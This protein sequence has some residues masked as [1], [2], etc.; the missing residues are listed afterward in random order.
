MHSSPVAVNIVKFILKILFSVFYRV[1]I[2]G[3][4]NIPE[5]GPVLLCSNHINELDMLFIGYRIRRTIHWMA[6][7]ELFE[8]P[9][10]GPLI[11]KLGAFPVRRGKGDVDSV[12]TAFSILEDGYIVGIFPEGTRVK[13]N[14]K[15]KINI[16]PGAA[17]L[18]AKAG[19]PILPVAVKGKLFP[20]S[21]IKIKFGKMFKLDTVM[22]KKYHNDELI[23]L[24]SKIM[25]KI[26]ILLE[27][28]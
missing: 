24:S 11:K 25:D 23:E 15:R 17:M 9:L 27:E 14:D 18:A 4:E 28:K 7:Q 1:K 8:I 19:V 13:A 21:V 10:L 12:K 6:K 3:R 16:K 26:R 5:K 20:F 22:G 2:S